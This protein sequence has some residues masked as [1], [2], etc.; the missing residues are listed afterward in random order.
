MISLTFVVSREWEEWEKRALVLARVKKNAFARIYK[1][2]IKKMFTEV[3]SI[4]R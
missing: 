1:S 3:E 4:I 2:V